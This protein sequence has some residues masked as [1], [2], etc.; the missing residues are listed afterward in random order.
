MNDRKSPGAKWDDAHGS[1]VMQFVE[2]SQGKEA[3]GRC[4]S[5]SSN[6]TPASDVAT[7][8]GTP[9][10]FIISDLARTWHDVVIDACI[11]AEIVVAVG[12]TACAGIYAINRMYGWCA[13]FLILAAVAGNAGAYMARNR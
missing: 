5:G 10:P 9:A 7:A 12:T 1:P 8:G 4:G 11:T 13:A 3:G 6:G 2:G